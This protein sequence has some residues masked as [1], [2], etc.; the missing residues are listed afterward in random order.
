MWASVRGRTE[1]I[2]LLIDGGVD[3]NAQDK[4][5]STALKWV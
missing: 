5:G 4:D 2:K 3:V 1:V